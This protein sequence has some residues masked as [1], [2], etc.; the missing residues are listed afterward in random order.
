MY[1]AGCAVYITLGRRNDRFMAMQDL[2]PRMRQLRRAGAIYAV[3]LAIAVTS[4]FVEKKVYEVPYDWA[5]Y[6]LKFGLSVWILA[7]IYLAV[8]IFRSAPKGWKLVWAGLSLC[9][10]PVGPVIMYT[11]A[12]ERFAKEASARAAT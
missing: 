6:F 10:Q 5:Q 8:L 3:A 12:K 1:V 7:S 11:L 4:A 2:E 9:L